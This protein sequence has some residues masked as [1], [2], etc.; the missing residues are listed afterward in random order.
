MPTALEPGSTFAGDFRIQKELYR[1]ARGDAYAAEQVSTGKRRALKVLP[2]DVLEGEGARERFLAAARRGAV[3]NSE[4][5][6]EVVA[7]GV[8]EVTGRAFVATEL[9]EGEDLAA[10]VRARGP[11]PIDD[12]REI[13]GQLGHALE[14]ASNEWVAHLGLKPENVLITRSRQR[15]AR[16]TVKVLDFGTSALVSAVRS[17]RGAREAPEIA[18]FAPEQLELTGDDAPAAI[19]AWAF[20]MLAFFLLTG[21]SY[22]RA[23]G[24][25][26]DLAKEIVLGAVTPASKRAAELGSNVRLPPGFDAWFARATAKEPAAR[27]MPGADATTALEAVLTKDPSLRASAGG[28]SSFKASMGQGPASMEQAPLS[29]LGRSRLGPAPLIMGASLLVVLLAVG[30]YVLAAARSRG[31]DRAACVASTGRIIASSK[32]PIDV[33]AYV[34]GGTPKRDAFIK[35][36]QSVLRDYER[37]S[38]GKLRVKVIEPVTEELKAEAKTRGLQEI[39]LADGDEGSDAVGITRG[40]L[41][42]VFQAGSEREAI[43]VLNPEAPHQLPF[44]ITNKIREVKARADGTSQRVGVLTGK[45]EIAIGEA[46]LVPSRGAAGPSLKSV[47]NQALP[48]YTLV[49]VDLRGGAEPVPSDVAALVVTQPGEA[50]TDEELKQID[51]F[52]MRGDK[53]LCIFAG[54][55][56][57]AAGDASMTAR[58]ATHGLERLLDGYGIE[59]KRDVVLDWESS[60]EIAVMERDK[61]GK[62]RFPGLVSVRSDP[63][64]GSPLNG[65]FVPFFGLEELIFPFPSTLT[66]HPEKQPGATMRAVARSTAKSTS[67][68]AETIALAPSDTLQPS[69]EYG[70]RVIAVGVEGALTSAFGAGAAKEARLLVVA[71]PQFLANPFTRAAGQDS[72]SIAGMLSQAYAQRY[73]TPMI[74]AF[75]NT[76]DWAIDEEDIT[77]CSAA[78]SAPK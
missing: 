49:D 11:L 57:V 71:S 17:K 33:T 46:N 39:A 64:E 59:L 73:L 20:G 78:L 54:A 62:M 9:L 25:A 69:G 34:T 14:A 45:R 7:V 63:G 22:F 21:R 60:A 65:A 5:V 66:P 6:I 67:S 38:R 76:L 13:M 30:I 53:G 29:V 74:L 32:A 3:I 44:W 43:P 35:E 12:V 4:H 15:G 68:A 8:D 61:P 19:D 37:E 77:A 51:A 56:N 40:F 52:L 58:L 50:F 24:S 70:S 42:V 48:F 36:L 18:F 41:G 28:G 2:A 16:F 55:A 72:E 23:E 26:E 1:G 31:A 47:I 10:A 75:K 27:F